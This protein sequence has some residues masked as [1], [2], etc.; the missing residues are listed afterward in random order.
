LI[1]PDASRRSANGINPGA[2]EE[3]RDIDAEIADLSILRH[4]ANNSLCRSAY[5]DDIT[6]TEICRSIVATPFSHALK[7][8]IWLQSRSS[9]LQSFSHSS[10]DVPKAIG[11]VPAQSALRISQTSLT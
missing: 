11:D 1:Y 3:F 2:A 10:I 5:A 7:W 4:S 6:R 8:S 9:S